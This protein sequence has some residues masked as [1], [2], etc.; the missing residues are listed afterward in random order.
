MRR[1]M[2]IVLSR[3][4]FDSNNGGVP[5]PIL[6]D[7]TVVFLPIPVQRSPT[8]FRDVRWRC[9]SLGTLVEDLTGG[10][11]LG[12]D[13]CHLD[14]DLQVG[15]LPRQPGWRPAFGQFKAA[16]GH[17]ASQSVGPGDLFLY[18]GLFRSV[19]QVAGGTWRYVQNAPWVHR[20][21]GWLQVS[22]VVTVGTDTVGARAARPWLSDHPHV[23]GQS[24]PPSNT[25][26]IS[27]R[28]LVIGGKETGADGGGLFS[29]ADDRLTLTAPEAP[30]HTYWRLPGWFWPR[31]RQPSLS[32]HRDEGR[33]RRGG[34]WAYVESAYPGQ[35]FVF[36]AAGIAE[37]DAWL[38]G[39]FDS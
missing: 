9:G 30:S 4:G 14:P 7:G 15:A 19:E 28:A 20:L 1:A 21:F 13:R 24:W 37:T 39:L 38:H 29:G 10:R 16:Q 8:R 35:E 31:D 2:K 36:N 22:E 12:E 18:F 23:N 17:L 32:Y 34:P 5:S 11:V 25:V 26:Y 27:P 3:K 6:P 33:W